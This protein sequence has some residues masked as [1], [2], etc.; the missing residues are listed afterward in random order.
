MPTRA[1]VVRLASFPECA[2]TFPE[3]A[4]T[5][6]E[7][8]RLEQWKLLLGFPRK[9]ES[10][11]AD[12]VRVDRC[13]GSRKGSGSSRGERA[14]RRVGSSTEFLGLAHRGD[15]SGVAREDSERVCAATAASC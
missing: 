2:D 15:E 1:R 9:R 7:F 8:A 13:L 6:P 12:C 10:E 11:R 3:C 14:G 4:D 5:F